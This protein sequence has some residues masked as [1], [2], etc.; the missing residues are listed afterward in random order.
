MNGGEVNGKEEKLRNNAK[1]NSV[2]SY[3]EE[4]EREERARERERERAY[5]HSIFKIRLIKVC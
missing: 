2:P 1:R 4:R 3:R 5:E